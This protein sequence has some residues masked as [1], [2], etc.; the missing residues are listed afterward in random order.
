MAS[1]K[2][3]RA[4]IMGAPGSGK[5][6]VSGRI[7]KVFHL[8]H[9]S[10]GDLLRSN[11]AKR[12]ELGL[13]ADNYIREGKLVPDIY[14]TK[15]ILNELEQI[16]SSSWL[17]DGFPRTREQA[18]DLWNQERIDSVINLDV[19]FDVIIERIQS[20]WVHLPS[21]RV[22]NVGFNDP[23]TPGRDDITGEPLSQ[24][25]DDNPVAVRKRLEVY[26]ACT[27][28]INEYFNEKG[29][30]VTFKGSTTDEIWPHVKQYLEAKVQ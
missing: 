3:F 8:K 5:G 25:P 22:Y 2:L 7:V 16:K 17:L 1:G 14:I 19:P 12:T 24:R 30:L 18:D 9:I 6:T 4:I 21:G 29:V 15:C 26:D 23:K 20:R 11:I 28:P 13:I 27:R 10:S